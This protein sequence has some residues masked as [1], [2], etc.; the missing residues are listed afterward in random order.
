MADVIAEV[1]AERRR[2]VAKGSTAEHD[3]G[4][5]CGEIALAAALYAIP[6]DNSLVTQDS[7]IEL[8]IAL[9]IGSRWTLKPEPDKRRRLVMAAAM[10]IAEIER[11][12]RAASRN[13]PR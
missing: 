4:H 9:E 10:I 2:Q 6:Y 1:A 5:S 12:D 3:D 8:Q 13:M 11:L 7:F